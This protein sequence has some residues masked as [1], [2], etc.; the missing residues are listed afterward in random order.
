MIYNTGRTRYHSYLLRLWRPDLDDLTYWHSS[1][2]DT[3][4]AEVHSFATPD[5]LW[6]FLVQAMEPGPKSFPTTSQPEALHP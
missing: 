4:T 5:D 3:L 6:S 2:Q 1:L